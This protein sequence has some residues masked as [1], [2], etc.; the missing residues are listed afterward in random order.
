V[1]ELLCG[2]LCK[3]YAAFPLSDA[4]RPPE[5]SKM[6]AV[7]RPCPAGPPAISQP[8][9]LGGRHLRAQ[10]PAPPTPPPPCRPPHS[11]T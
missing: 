3:L 2:V 1:V 7:R 8:F 4:N 9:V 5:A 10:T 11:R 6:Q